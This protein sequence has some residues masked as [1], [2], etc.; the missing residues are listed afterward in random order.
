[1]GCLLIDATTSDYT[2]GTK[3]PYSQHYA[4]KLP[5]MTIVRPDIEQEGKNVPDW[6]SVKDYNFPHLRSYQTFLEKTTQRKYTRRFLLRLI[7]MFLNMRIFTDIL[8]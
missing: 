6:N 8:Q 2:Q 3:L 4:G 7:S 5:E 1:M